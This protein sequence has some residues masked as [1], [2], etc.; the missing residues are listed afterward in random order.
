VPGPVIW[1]GQPGFCCRL[2]R[3]QALYAGLHAVEERGA[4]MATTIQ[5]RFDAPRSNLEI[6]DLQ[7][8][9]VSTR[10][11]NVRAAVERGLTVLDSFLAA[12]MR[13]QQ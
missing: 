6:T 13:D 11:T 7:S 5:G 2:K 8:T 4:F 12:H 1:G 10:Q 9:T 3:Y